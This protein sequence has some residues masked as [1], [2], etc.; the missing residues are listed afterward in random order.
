MERVLKEALSNA[1]EGVRARPKSAKKRSLQVVNEH[2]EPVFN[3][4][5]ATQ[6]IIQCFLNPLLLLVVL[7]F[8]FG[9]TAAVAEGGFAPEQMEAFD[10]CLAKFDQKDVAEYEKLNNEYSSRI[11][12]LC[13][14]KNRGEAQRL[15]DELASIIESTPVYTEIVGCLAVFVDDGDDDDEDYDDEDYAYADDEPEDF[16]FHV[17]GSIG[18]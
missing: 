6:V 18:R 13:V 10:Q 5:L 2:F 3:A 9:S 7:A 11:Y 8:S 15:H 14:S 12:D 17:C 4:P 1:G 16:D